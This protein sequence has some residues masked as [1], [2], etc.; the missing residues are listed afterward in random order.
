[1]Q[2]QGPFA[3][4]GLASNN[5]NP[6]TPTSAASAS[7]LGLGVEPTVYLDEKK[8]FLDHLNWIRRINL[9]PDQNDSS[10][11]GLYVVRL[12]VSIT[13]GECTYQGHG[14]DITFTVEHEF[15]P[16]FLPA[17]FKNLVINDVAD[18]LGPVIYELIR[19]GSFDKLK[20]KIDLGYKAKILEAQN[21]S[22][23]ESQRDAIWRGLW[24]R[25]CNSFE[26]RS[27]Q[28]HPEKVNPYDAIAKPLTDFILRSNQPLSGDPEQDRPY[29]LTIVKRLSYLIEAWRKIDTGL[30]AIEQRKDQMVADFRAKV[31]NPIRRGEN[32]NS[33][34]VRGQVQ[35]IARLVVYKI[36]A[37]E[38]LPKP[39]EFE[40][41]MRLDKDT[42]FALETLRAK[43]TPSQ[44][45]VAIIE[46]L[47]KTVLRDDMEILDGVLNSA[48]AELASLRNVITKV[49]SN[50]DELNRSL[51]PTFNISLPSVRS[52]KQ[53][54]PIAP[55]ELI[56]FF[57]E[58]NVY[59]LA[60]DAKDAS[61]P[62]TIRASEVR[63]YLR[64]T[65]ETAYYAMAYPT[66]RTPSGMLPPLADP[67][68]LQRLLVAIH[69]R[70]FGDE[71]ID[72]DTAGVSTDSNKTE[73]DKK[74]LSQL[75]EE[76]VNRLALSRENISQKPIGAL[77]W[78]IAVDAAVLDFALR[79][80]ARKVFEAKDLPCD[81]LET[82][83]FYHP[84]QV[85]NDE[86][87]AVFCEYVRQRWPIITFALDPVTDQQNIADSFNLKRDLQLAVS[88]AFAT[89]QINFSQL[90]T[91][92]RQ[93][94]QSSDTIALNRTVTGFANNNDTFGFRFSPRFQN[95]PSQK[96]NLAVIASQLISGG[97]GP[98]YQTR[99]SK[100]EP[101]MRELTA[102][103]LIP[104]FL[105]TMRVNLAANWFKLTDP[106]HLI[107][108]TARQMER[109]RRVQE[110]RAAAAALCNA[111]EYRGADYRVLQSKLEQLEAMLPMQSRVIQLPFENSANGFDLFSEGATALVPELT[112]YSGV[113][114]ITAPASSSGGSAAST[115]SSTAT[116]AS[117]PP[118]TFSVTS[119]TTPP[120]TAT[121]TIN[122]GTTSIADIF[123]FG[124]Y[125]SLLDSRV[126]AGG[127]SA[128]FEV[129]SREVL[130]VQIP[131]N[132][133]ATTTDDNKTYIEVYVATPNGISNSL[134]VPY[135]P[136]TPAPQVAY[137]VPTANQSIA[138]YYQWLPSADQSSHSLVATVDPGTKGLPIT[139]DSNTGLAPK[140]I[141]VQFTAIVNNQNVVLTLQ[142]AAGT[143][144]DYTIDLQQF[145]VT[146]L[147]RLQDFTAYPAL[148]TSPI[149][150][151]VSVQPWQP[152]D[153]EGLRV[154]TA[155]K[156]L[157]SKVTVNLQ[158]NDTG[159][160]VLPGVAPAPPPPPPPAP[161]AAGG[162]RRAG[163]IPQPTSQILVSPRSGTARTRR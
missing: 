20:T 42:R 110:L 76:L 120:T 98:N 73:S 97:P 32:P 18:Q 105:P 131:A 78:A 156:P 4:L 17:T 35:A 81:A 126:I 71:F 87:K 27:R 159:A 82:V 7:A 52:A 100:L 54:Y 56:R 133:I 141:Q 80:D 147:K 57:L 50:N 46:N 152:A 91:F 151:T 136:A 8:R 108:H 1:M 112:G 163:G 84:P 162:A 28:T 83:R 36:L 102:T 161:A 104:T 5:F 89:G 68:F 149:T 154:R 66:E 115:S 101:G 77:C 31:I 96:T 19:S 160:N 124:K 60:K 72:G 14:A 150:F 65:L 118:A 86:G 121:Y 139:W 70:R 37:V 30:P 62:A 2:G 157:K 6:I 63:S 25:W 3:N 47:Y 153:S 107:F 158:Y 10:G 94:E 69:E 117:P 29:L 61:R 24:N 119:L 13:P 85:A 128:S 103:L 23:L 12:P 148:P 134:L 116:T 33:P 41:D 99:K 59:I 137:D 49:A 43:T 11:Y 21:D 53:F 9:G 79:V 75:Y 93:I 111:H 88:F 140:R 123:V 125:I 90:N 58:E 122:G 135:L 55:R 51:S 142:A 15:T 74:G 146:L 38:E 92:R 145:A 138:F 143:Q 34:K 132:V 109:G 64:Q 129:L 130:H 44:F 106:E 127:K 144:D 95:P 155:P 113:D 22:L 40:K 48:P 114:V 16:D 39:Y 45:N 26:E 67:E